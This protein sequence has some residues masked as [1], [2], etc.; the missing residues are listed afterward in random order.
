CGWCITTNTCKTGASSAGSSD[1]TCSGT[2]WAWTSDKCPAAPTVTPP[3]GGA[4]ATPTPT[5][6][7][8]VDTNSDGVNDT[9]HDSTEETYYDGCSGVSKVTYR[10]SAG[11]CT[12][13][14]PSSCPAGQACY[15]SALCAVPTPTPV[16]TYSIKGVVYIDTNTDGS[17]QEPPE[18]VYSGPVTIRGQSHEKGMYEIK[19]LTAG[20]YTVSYTNI[21]AS[22]QLTYPANGSFNVNLPCSGSGAIID[23]TGNALNDAE[24]LN[25]SIINLNF[26]INTSS[27]W[28]QSIGGNMRVDSNSGF[29]NVMPS[30][31]LFASDAAG[32]DRM[33]GIIFSG[34]NRPTYG[35]GSANKFN[36][37]VAG[38]LN[39]PLT[40]IYN[41]IPTS[42]GYILGTSEGS[43]IPPTVI[44]DVNSSMTHGIYKTDGGLTI[45]TPVTF[46]TDCGLPPCNYIILI[47]G[48]LTINEEIKVPP[49]STAIFSASGN[50]TVGQN[51]GVLDPASLVPN[52]EGLYSADKSFIA[53]GANNCSSGSDKRLNIAGTVVANAGRAGGT[54]DN[55]RNL[56]TNNSSYPS[57]TFI[58]RPDFILH[59]PNLTQST[60]KIWQE[61]NP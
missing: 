46:R 26:G 50:I 13:D 40:F 12:V 35:K 31:G 6:C 14:P 15:S 59:Y 29:V 54:F 37:E 33:P 7:Y 17:K 11:S 30:A 34:K 1:G 18:T 38:S 45:N 48:N 43:G 20:T 61:V 51:I 23:T 60:T 22:Y 57:V 4:T 5:G 44:E 3:G 47:N 58:E 9:C 8:K 27:A 52:I 41:P 21:P 39:N 49:G 28:I 53:A 2:N 56:C 10:C 42:Y 16:P 32:A 19:N 25:G 36:W 55:R 24:C